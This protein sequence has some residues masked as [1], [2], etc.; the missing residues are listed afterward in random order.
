MFRRQGARWRPCRGTP[1]P[2][3]L[4]GRSPT[5]SCSRD[6]RARLRCPCRTCRSLLAPR[7]RRQRRR[8]HPE[9]IVGEAQPGV[10][11]H[12]GGIPESR[13]VGNFKQIVAARRLLDRVEE[14]FDRIDGPRFAQRPELAPRGVAQL[15]RHAV[16]HLEE[17]RRLAPRAEA[18]DGY[19]DLVILDA[20]GAPCRPARLGLAY[21]RVP[22]AGAEGRVRSSAKRWRYD[23][24]A[25][26]GHDGWGY[27][28]RRT[29]ASQ[30]QGAAH[31]HQDF[32]NY[33]TALNAFTRPA[34]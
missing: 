9:P 20:Q 21:D 24:V 12:V 27:R 30:H 29:V 34:P 3:E 7:R 23:G 10:P 16:P 26:D 17:R 5:S 33:R 2:L 14:P 15:H 32:T 11:V 25:D 28:G 8:A 22:L 1:D 13:V 19:L 18:P 31:G 6:G 4:E